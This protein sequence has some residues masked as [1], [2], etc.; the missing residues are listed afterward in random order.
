MP[1]ETKKLPIIPV[2]L[3]GG[4]GSRLWPLSRAMRPK[5]FIK[6]IDRDRSLFQLT[7]DRIQDLDNVIHTL[8]VCNQDHRFTVAEQVLDTTCDK[9]ISII[10][11]PC[12]RNTAPAIAS[13][14]L[15]VKEVL[16]IEAALLLVLPA[17]H[18]IS[19][20]H[21][22]LQSV[23]L[24][25]TEATNDQLLTFGIHP[26][27][28]ATGYGYIKSD[29]HSEAI[30]KVDS[31]IEKPA[32]EAA[33]KYFISNEYSWNSG[34]FLFSIE[35]YLN[36]LQINKPDILARTA[37][38]VSKSVRDSDFCRL[39]E[40]EYEKCESISIDYA[41]MEHSENVSVIKPDIKWNDVGSW[42]SVWEISE[43]DQDGNAIIGDVWTHN[44]QNCYLH[45]ENKII[46][47]VGV[48]DIV[49]IETLDG[50]M[51]THKDADQDVKNI[52]EQLITSG[53]SEALLHR[54][55]YRPWGNYDSIDAGKRFQVK[56]ITVT[57]GEVLSLQKHFHRAEHWIVVSGTAEVTKGED[58]FLLNENE[59]TYIPLGTIHKLKNPGKIPLEIIEVQSG[60]YLGED[61]IE[62]I[63][64]IYGR[65]TP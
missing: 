61:D 34:I 62:R 31:F 18:V 45:A 52:V 5:Q 8:V 6:L 16:K 39:D 20:G 14:A 33:E 26:T 15:Y 49:V 40:T 64:D 46:A 47:A 30:S 9:N 10:L 13:A 38:A 50:V 25:S 22:F 17:D 60:A 48:K 29:P 58:V 32:L 37:A 53:R 59:S 11:E 2:I 21:N 1:T 28:P 44:A 23:Q 65:K 24:A 35:N 7:L 55:V 12:A 54:K 56:R 36:E 43:K 19:S 27:Y 41:V 3:S 4:S 51:V 57:P 63:D 42:S